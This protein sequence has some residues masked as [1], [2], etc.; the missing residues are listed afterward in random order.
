MGPCRGTDMS[1][2]ARWG[3]MPTWRVEARP[4]QGAIVSAH[5]RGRA[6]THQR[7]RGGKGQ[8]R[9]IKGGGDIERGPA[10]PRQHRTRSGGKVGRP[11]RKDPSQVE[12]AKLIS[13]LASKT[14]QREKVPMAGLERGHARAHPSSNA[15]IVRVQAQTRASLYT[16]PLDLS[17]N[18]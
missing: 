2:T 6:S 16:R 3:T 17:S 4:C 8:R 9:P 14:R 5:Q 11:R 15:P 18:T 1:A 7:Q 13:R 12:A 10:E